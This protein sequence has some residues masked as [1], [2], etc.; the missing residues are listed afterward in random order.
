[1]NSILQ[2]VRK[3]VASKEDPAASEGA[4]DTKPQTTA[5]KTITGSKSIAKSSI[6][7]RKS[8]RYTVPQEHRSC[9]LKVGGNVLSAALVNESKTGFAVL[10]D[11]LDGL[12]VGE[13][14]ELNTDMGRFTVQI[15][16]VSEVAP[17]EYA[18]QC[19]SLFRLGVKKARSSFLVLT[20]SNDRDT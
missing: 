14:V 17:P 16:Y 6:D 19:K 7:D 5:N 9:E 3:L 18:T 2:K 20:H 10:I 13:K 12:E 11:R 8:H 1:M 15:V 4:T